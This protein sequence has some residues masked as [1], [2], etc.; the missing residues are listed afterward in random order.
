MGVESIRNKYCFADASI[1]YMQFLERCRNSEEGGKAGLAKATAKINVKAEVAT[2][3]PTKEDELPKQLKY[4]QHQIDALV[5]QVK[6]LV[7]LVRSAQ[8]SS[9]VART[10]TPSYG[11]GAHGK[12]TSSTGGGGSWVKGPSSQLGATVQPKGKNPQQGQGTTKTNKPNQWWQCGEVG[13]LKRDCP[14][15]KGKGLFQEGNA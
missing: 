5:G 9:R 4:Q 7:A 6:D 11:R 12:R 10:R 2:L 15:L 14:T 1:D 13:H 3:P 8:P